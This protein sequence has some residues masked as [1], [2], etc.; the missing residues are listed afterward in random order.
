ME[1]AEPYNR[2]FLRL[3][4]YPQYYHTEAISSKGIKCSY[5]LNNQSNAVASQPATILR[6]YLHM[7]AAAHDP[8][9]V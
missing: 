2:Y 9:K 1:A 8:S 7:L 5:W 3:S 6:S 4:L